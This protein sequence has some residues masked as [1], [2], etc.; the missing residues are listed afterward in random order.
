MVVP[1]TAGNL[2]AGTVRG[3]FAFT[4]Q[5][6]RA[7]PRAQSESQRSME[8]SR[9]SGPPWRY[10]SLAVLVAGL[11]LPSS[12]DALSLSPDHLATG[13]GCGV[14]D[15]TMTRARPGLVRSDRPARVAPRQ[16]QAAPAPAKPVPEMPGEA[17]ATARH[18]FY[19]CTSA[20]LF[21]VPVGS[22]WLAVGPLRSG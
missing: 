11:A 10:A 9:P 5:P 6:R 20:P 21:A 15:G 8:T 12:A 13:P 22:G 14:A 18:A 3:G 17:P 4:G 16:R 19:T 2:I 7:P 1:T